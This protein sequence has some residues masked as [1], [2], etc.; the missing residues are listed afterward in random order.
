[1]KSQIAAVLAIIVAVFLIR[2]QPAIAGPG[3]QIRKR[4]A[5]VY[6]ARFLKGRKGM[7]SK[8]SIRSAALSCMDAHLRRTRPS[9][10]WSVAGWNRIDPKTLS[11]K[12]VELRKDTRDAR[13]Y[14][15]GKNETVFRAVYSAMQSDGRGKK[16]QVNLYLES[17]M[18]LGKKLPRFTF[19]Y[20]LPWQGK[21]RTLPFGV[22]DPITT[23]WVD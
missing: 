1:M 22:P 21:V 13:G 5:P 18:N 11:L 15:L 7:I 2:V 16:K 10:T 17:E 3:A 20:N 14:R 9:G 4:A 6:G 8:P 23:S 19:R 12:R